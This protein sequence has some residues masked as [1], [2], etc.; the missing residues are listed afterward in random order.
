ME[1]V[2]AVFRPLKDCFDRTY[3]YVMSCGDYIEA[4][5]H[6]MNELK[7]KRD[8]IKRLVDG[9]ERHSMEATSQVKWWLKCVADLEVAALRIE[10]DYR[11]RQRL[12]PER[13]PGIMATY[14]LSKKADEMRAEAAR[15]KEKGNFD[16]VADEL[17]QIRV[18]EMPSVPVFG[19]EAQLQELNACVRDGGITG[20]YG[21]AG[22]GKTELLNKF[23]NE[24]LINSQDINV[25][26]YIEVGRKFN[27]DDFQRI[28]GDRIGVPWEDNKLP[29]ERGKVLF[30]VLS[31]MNFVLLL[32][33]V[34]EPIK[35]QFLGIPV[36][37]QNSMSKIVLTTRIEDVCDRMDVR[38]KLK[39]ECLPL[40]PAWELFCEKVG[41]HLMRASEEIRDHAMALAMKC[42]GHPLALITVGRAMASRRDAKEWK[43]AI[44]VLE[45]APWQLLGMDTEVLV[46]LQESYNYLPNDM[47]RLC[48]LYCSLFPEELSIPKDSIV[49]YCI[50][51]GF[52]DDLFTMDEEFYFFKDWAKIASL[53]ERGEDADHIRIHPMVRA[54]ALWIASEFGKKETKWLVRAGVGLKEAPGADK[55]SDAERI[56]FMG[57][58]IV[59]LYERPN[60]PLLKTLLLQ[61]N[62]LS[63][64]CDGFFQFMPSL[65]V[66]DLSHTSLSELPSGISSLVELRY[67][68]LY[69]TNI[70]SLPM[71]L[72]SLVKLRFL[73]LSKVP[74][75]MIPGGVICSLTMLQVLY[76]DHSYGDWTVGDSGSCVSFQELESLRRLQAL[77]I[78]IQS[79]ETLEQLSRSYRLA[80]STRNLLIK[81]CSSLTNLELTSANLWKNMSNLKRVWI[82]RCSNLAEVIIDR[83]KETD[84][85]I[86]HSRDKLQGRPI[87][88]GEQ[89]ILPNLHDLIL[90][91]LPKVK[92]I[93]R[94]G[95][96]P[97]LASL[98]IQ[99][100]H[101]L[102]ELLT[103]SEKDPEMAASDGEEDAGTTK[104]IIPFPNLK[105]LHLHGLANFRTLS[106]GICMLQFPSLE[107][108]KIVE[109]PVLKKLKLCASGLNKI[110]CTR[111]WWDGLQWEDEEAKESFELLLRPMS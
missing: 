13:S 86:K 14:Y 45:S 94:E 50:G 68:D 49:G 102:E 73:I 39:M 1:F 58:H 54:M 20:I 74:L 56:S 110:Q 29:K 16:K 27:Q 63:R 44:T 104:V 88:D 96:V 43:H 100:C 84:D 99:Y 59:E 83:I 92:I 108:L 62:P 77:D 103:L 12:R 6:E 107:T 69:N 40:E 82:A 89:H 3:G 78:T 97:N 85:R 24:F 31:K 101:G 75:E 91:G 36:L 37:K 35:L 19:M 5:G 80:V 76:M 105:E 61:S 66:L 4:M 98:F 53:Q 23:N 26:I 21:M 64:I 41:E 87:V 33:D 70:R 34:W 38:R 52:T 106:S 46:P 109:C 57:N 25:V 9:A 11:A 15:I 7:S 18:E 65:R 67:L 10:D 60:C 28:I 71:E 55:W 79:L 72:E 48:L 95:C 22:V 17:V 32:D 111:E 81:T 30:R 47:I 8:D 42:G 90:Q 2:A 93:Y 51:E